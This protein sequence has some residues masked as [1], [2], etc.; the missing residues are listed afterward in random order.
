MVRTRHPPL[1]LNH[2]T[3]EIPGRTATRKDYADTPSEACIF[4]VSFCLTVT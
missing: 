4:F 2:A 1:P 3:P